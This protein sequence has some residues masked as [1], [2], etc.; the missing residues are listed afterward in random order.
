MSGSTKLHSIGQSRYLFTVRSTCHSS[1]TQEEETQV[2]L[3]SISPA[4]AELDCQR[5]H[6][7]PQRA[8]QG[9]SCSLQPE[10]FLPGADIFLSLL[11]NCLFTESQNYTWNVIIIITPIFVQPHGSLCSHTTQ[12]ACTSL[13]TTSTGESAKRSRDGFHLK[14]L[15]P[16]GL[17]Q[18]PGGSGSAPQCDSAHG[19][20]MAQGHQAAALRGAWRRTQ[21]TTQ[22]VHDREGEMAAHTH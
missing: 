17:P 2:A 10:A 6:E 15:A 19:Q 8:H 21:G 7:T 3:Q 1:L 4:A 12:L 22:T 11:Q 16:E 18:I 20:H 5:P 13:R 9:G 14:V